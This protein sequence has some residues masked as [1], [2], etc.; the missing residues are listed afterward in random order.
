M[1]YYVSSYIATSEEDDIAFGSMY[2][3]KITLTA[4]QIDCSDP[5]AGIPFIASDPSLDQCSIDSE[6]VENSKVM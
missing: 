5:W 1:Y 4:T 2:F 3:I 6:E